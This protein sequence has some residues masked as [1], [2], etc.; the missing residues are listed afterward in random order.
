MAEEVV[1][2]RLHDPGV[3]DAGRQTPKSV[4]SRA[5]TPAGM[6]VDARVRPQVASSSAREVV[7]NRDGSYKDLECATWKAGC[8]F[9]SKCDPGVSQSPLTFTVVGVARV[10]FDGEGQGPPRCRAAAP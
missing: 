2:M 10:P 3:L 8:P 7:V 6:S 1:P 5:W 9:A 4:D